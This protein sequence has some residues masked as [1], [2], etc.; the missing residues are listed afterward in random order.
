MGNVN[1]FCKLKNSTSFYLPFFISAPI[2]GKFGKCSDYSK[3]SQPCGGGIQSRTRKCDSPVPANGGADCVGNKTQTRECSIKPCPVNGVFGK[4]SE[5]STC[6]VSCG[7]GLQYRERKCNSPSP[8]YGGKDCDGPIR[9]SRTCKETECPGRLRVF[10]LIRI[11]MS[12]VFIPSKHLENIVTLI[13]P[14]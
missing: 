10:S 7:G 14:R 2:G 4:W 8:K 11:H 13:E 6:T 5:Y 9:E 1:Y 3:C 12:C